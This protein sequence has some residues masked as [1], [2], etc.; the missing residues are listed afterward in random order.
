MKILSSPNNKVAYKQLDQPINEAGSRQTSPVIDEELKTYWQT[1][2]SN[3]D[4]LRTTSLGGNEI[5]LGMAS[6]S[7]ARPM[8]WPRSESLQN[9]AVLNLKEALLKTHDY[10]RAPD[11]DG[12]TPIGGPGKNNKITQYRTRNFDPMV[13]FPPVSWTRS[14]INLFN[15]MI[16][17]TIM[18]LPYAMMEI[19]LSAPI[20]MLLTV[21]SVYQSTIVMLE[22]LHEDGDLSKPQLRYYYWHVSSAAFGKW[23]TVFMANFQRMSYL[24]DNG[25]ALVLSSNSMGSVVELGNFNWLIIFC[26]IIVAECIF[27]PNQKALTWISIIGIFNTLVCCVTLIVIAAGIIIGESDI[28]NSFASTVFF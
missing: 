9:N 5:Y 20:V 17:T 4:L 23:G 13:W 8:S 15:N 25:W 1:I 24:L 3:A 16:G 21:A 22:T 10:C 19:G 12:T 6:V 14:L 7:R 26:G 18:A 28:W 11:N 2:D 27:F